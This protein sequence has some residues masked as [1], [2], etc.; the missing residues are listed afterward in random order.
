MAI[1]INNSNLPYSLD[2]EQTVLGT[3]VLDSAAMAEVTVFLK[4]EHFHVALH[5][6]LFGVLYRMFI[7]N[8]PIDLVTIIES[9]IQQKVFENQDEARSYLLKMAESV[10]NPSGIADYARIIEEK[11]MIRN[12]MYACKEVFDMASTGAEEPQHIMDYA[13][14]KVFELRTERDS[15]GLIH[16]KPFIDSRIKELKAIQADPHKSRNMSTSFNDLDKCIHGLAPSNLIIIAGR[17]GMGKTSLAVNIAIGAAMKQPK[18]EVVIFSFEM[19]SE[20]LVSRIISSEAMITADQ[21]R[22]GQINKD[23]WI[24]IANTAER[25]SG[26]ELYIDDS[27]NVSIGEM[28]AKLRRKTNLGLVVIDHL[29]LMSTGRRDGN[30]VQEVSEIT[31]NIK[32]MAKDL[33]VPVILVSQLSRLNE[34]RSATN[35]RPVLSDLRESGSIEQDSDI[36]LMLYREHYYNKEFEKP[37][38]CECIIAKNRHGE[39]CTIPLNWDERYTKF[40]SMDFKHA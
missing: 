33:D 18:K 14:S 16:I 21:M 39:T 12:L 7:T 3:I 15:G 23:G 26:L 13:E 8:M 30:R 31:R 32:L 6:D 1:E 17:P 40:T 22:Y 37:N 2:A 19:S 38:L 36:V 28:K 10:V 11:H 34:N 24:N 5:R 20:Q 29:N 35:K 9:T 4:P 27:P 25:L